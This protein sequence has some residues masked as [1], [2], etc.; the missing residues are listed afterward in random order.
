M[1]KAEKLIV[2]RFV[3]CKQ[4]HHGH[5]PLLQ[6]DQSKISKQNEKK[7]SKRFSALGKEFI[8]SVN[9]V[10]LENQQLTFPVTKCRRL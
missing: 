4:Q 8:I 5:L 2:M 9:Q 10:A 3:F 1:R 7:K 6:C